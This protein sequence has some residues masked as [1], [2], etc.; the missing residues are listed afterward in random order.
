[1]RVVRFLAKLRVTDLYWLFRG[2]ADRKEERTFNSLRE[3]KV[4]HGSGRQG[5]QS[6]AG[7]KDLR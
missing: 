4:T 1:M 5:S 3:E 7:D 2:Q 6:G